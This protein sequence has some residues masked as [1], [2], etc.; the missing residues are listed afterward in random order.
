MYP[1]PNIARRFLESFLA[2][3]VPVMIG[4]QDR[5]PVLFHRLDKIDFD[6][7]KKTRIYRFIETHSH[8]RYESGVQDFDMTILGET[9]DILNDLLELVE[10]EDKKHYDF[11]AES[12]G[13]THRVV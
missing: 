11:L 2:F 7:K 10:H 12:V 5:E 4:G 9:L 1:I 3:R 13:S 6:P 8:P